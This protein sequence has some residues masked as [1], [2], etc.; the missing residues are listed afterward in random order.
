MRDRLRSAVDGGPCKSRDSWADLLM[1]RE[2]DRSW[3][4]K[5]DPHWV[6]ECE[7][8]FWVEGKLLSRGHAG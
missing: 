2:V 5:I 7:R 8:L 6:E 4:E 1:T 3:W